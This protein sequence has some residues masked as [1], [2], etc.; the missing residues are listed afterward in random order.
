M[1][2]IQVGISSSP[3]MLIPIA[4]TTGSMSGVFF[5]AFFFG[6][7]LQNTRDVNGGA[8]RRD[9]VPA[10]Y[11]KQ[12]A[13]LGGKAILGIGPGGQQQKDHVVLGGTGGGTHGR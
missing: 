9:N 13:R 12:P 5:P 7:C 6:D 10:R 11:N 2:C 3:E 4:R 8:M 1:T